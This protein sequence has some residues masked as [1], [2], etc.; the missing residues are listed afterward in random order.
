MRIISI[1]LTAVLMLF[2]CGNGLV[3]SKTPII[4]LKS[5]TGQVLAP[6]S[7]ERVTKMVED[8]YR[9][10]SDTASYSQIKVEPVK[11]NKGLPQ[12]IIVYRFYR[13]QYLFEMDRVIIDEN[14][15]IVR[16]EKNIQEQTQPE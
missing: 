16:V 8:Y 3:Q 10:K 9:L 6:Q 5:N 12:E 15:S 14:F 2:A 7:A 13:D 11:I 4:I 1:S